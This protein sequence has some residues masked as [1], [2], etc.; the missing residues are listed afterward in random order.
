MT[1]LQLQL[2]TFTT[3]ESFI[4]QLP[5]LLGEL[6]SQP[7]NT[8]IYFMPL[9]LFNERLRDLLWSLKTGSKD[10]CFIFYCEES[11]LLARS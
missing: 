9:F 8:Q 11:N 7:E 1:R 3:F 5:I 10:I 6:R 2:E 4:G